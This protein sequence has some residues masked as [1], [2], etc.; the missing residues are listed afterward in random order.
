MI[1]IKGKYTSADVMIDDIE[2]NCYK[3]I[4][5]FVNNV[6]MTNPIKIMPD[7]H[8]GKGS[9][10][11]FTMA[12]GDKLNPEI[13]GVDVG[14]GMLSLKL[15][16][17]IDAKDLEDIDRKIREAVP[18]GTNTNN[19]D[20]DFKKSFD[21]KEVTKRLQR[22]VTYRGEFT[23]MQ[24]NHMIEKFGCK[25]GRIKSSIGSLGG[26]NHF[27]EIGK[28]E[29]GNYWLTIHTGSRNLGKQ[30]CEYHTNVAKTIVKDQITNEYQSAIN[31]IKQNCDKSTWED[32]FKQL[33]AIYGRNDSRNQ[34]NYYLK[35]D[36][37]I[38]YLEDMIVAQYYAEVNRSVIASKILE[39]LNAKVDEKVESVHNYL[40]FDD[41]IIR[42]GAISSYE[43]QKLIIPW[44][45]RDG[46]IIGKG[47]SNPDWNYS[48]P[49][50]AGRVLS[51]SAA[52]RSIEL[53]DFKGQMEGIYSTSVCSSTLDEAPD[54]YK[55]YQVIKNAI[56][57]TVEILHT[58]KPILNIKAL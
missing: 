48:A 44:N 9:C 47:K 33:K 37:L 35:D 34:D 1:T 55:D 29:D 45:M 6:A 19:T 8:A 7:C 23:E 13:I 2:E 57:P 58:V 30:V 16:K 5:Q 3:Q 27:I 11:G 31:D 54:A 26:G 28:D 50:G 22:E 36:H 41:N 18:M 10:I 32:N 40:D 49:H 53:D 12:F 39:I 15:S 4:N 20:N 38:D 24:F 43:G 14:C 17:H 21:F 25:I 51:R 56:G 42:K 52:K 46:L